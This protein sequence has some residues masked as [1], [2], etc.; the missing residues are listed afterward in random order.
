MVAVGHIQCACL[1]G[2]GDAFVVEY[3]QFNPFESL[4]VLPSIFLLFSHSLQRS[5]LIPLRCML[6]PSSSIFLE[7]LPP[8]VAHNVERQVHGSTVAMSESLLMSPL[9]GDVWCSS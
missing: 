8:L 3:Q 2:R 7:P 4:E 9:A 1:L 5:R 6:R